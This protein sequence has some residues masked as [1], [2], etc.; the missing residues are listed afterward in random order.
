MF[1]TKRKHTIDQYIAKSNPN[2]AIHPTDWGRNFFLNKNYVVGPTSSGS[3]H[4]QN[5]NSSIVPDWFRQQHWEDSYLPEKKKPTLYNSNKNKRNGFR[6]CHDL[7]QVVLFLRAEA[8]KLRRRRRDR[9]I[10][11]KIQN[12][13]YRWKEARPKKSLLVPYQIPERKLKLVPLASSAIDGAMFHRRRHKKKPACYCWCTEH[14]NEA[15]GIRKATHNRSKTC[16]S[17]FPSIVHML[18]LL[19]PPVKADTHRE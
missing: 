9:K 12:N 18:L 4:N 16:K 5:N 11:N 14:R 2:T 19:I 8:Q 1:L 10:R 7:N 3:S 6:P 17:F 15:T 13:S